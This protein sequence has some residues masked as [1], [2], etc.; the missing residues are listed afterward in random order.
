MEF[1]TFPFAL[2]FLIDPQINNLFYFL[3]LITGSA[4]NLIFRLVLRHAELKNVNHGVHR[5]ALVEV[6]G[7]Q[8]IYHWIG[9]K[10][11]VPKHVKHNLMC[12]IS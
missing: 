5:G 3:I 7:T 2:F 12:I 1:Q 8:T 9:L 6:S 11:M 4:S 10:K